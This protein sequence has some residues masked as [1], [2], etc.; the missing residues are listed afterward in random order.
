MIPIYSTIRN[1]LISLYT[2]L[3]RFPVS[4][5]VT[6]S[7]A[8]LMIILNHIS[9]SLNQHTMDVLTRIIM[10]LLLGY[11]IFLC[12]KLLWER[13]IKE[14]KD[15]LFLQILIQISGMLVLIFYYFVL[16]PDFGMIS[17]SRYAAVTLAS[18]LSFLFIP[19]FY[20]REAFELYTVRILVRFFTTAL[21]SAV[22]FAGLSAILFT[23]NKLLGVSFSDKLYFD[24]F[25]GVAAIFAPWFF[26][27]GIPEKGQTFLQDTYPKLLKILFLYIIMPLLAIYGVILYIYFA[28]V[29][30]TRQWP[31]GLVAHLVLWYSV[32]STIVIFFVTPFLQENKWVKG[33]SSWYPRFILPILVVMFVS[34]GI[35]IQ[36]YGITENRY[37]VV[38]LGLWVTGSMIYLCLTKTKRNMPLLVSLALIILLSVFGPWSSYNLSVWSQNHRLEGILAK[39]DRLQN[40][41]LHSS[42]KTVGQ[43]D[44]DEI[45]QILSYFS[46]THKVSDI[47]SFPKNFKLEQ[48]KKLIGFEYRTPSTISATSTDQTF[49]MYSSYAQGKVINIKGYDAYFDL[50]ANGS[51][52]TL[53][54]TGLEVKYDFA[55]MKLQL[56]LDGKSVYEKQLSSFGKQLFDKYGPRNEENLTPEDM[57]FVEEN[58]KIRIKLILLSVNGNKEQKDGAPLIQGLDFYLLMQVK[59]TK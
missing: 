52:Q 17:I 42:S 10:I 36:A 45:N 13:H 37:F 21:Y 58:D 5:S 43:K 31:I 16:L 49:F 38:V 25:L 1:N 20:E 35:R 47:T 29:L 40:G 24:L 27:A 8:V 14:N 9:A 34:I 6:T 4:I 54:N 18:Y 26:M 22:L 19:Y 39:Y 44:E 11:P 56:Y 2:S 55:S 57:S 53:T 50:K 15:P 12:S 51:N 46:N 7:A 48:T 28:K 3:K 32:I 30:I 59:T 33:F 41:K 23:I